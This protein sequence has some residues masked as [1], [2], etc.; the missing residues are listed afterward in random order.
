[1]DQQ[2]QADQLFVPR[3][4]QIVDFFWTKLILVSELQHSVFL[5]DDFVVVASVFRYAGLSDEMPRSE[6]AG[7]LQACRARRQISGS[8]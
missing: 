4:Q 2:A 5:L 6:N 8:E 7:A 3:R 1:M